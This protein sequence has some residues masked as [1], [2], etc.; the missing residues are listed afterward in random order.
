MQPE[1]P[2]DRTQIAILPRSKEPSC[3]EWIVLR[4]AFLRGPLPINGITPYTPAKTDKIVRVRIGTWNLE[5]KWSPEH[6]ALL[7]RAD[8]DVWLLTEV[9][10]DASIPGMQVHRTAEVMRPQKA[11]AAIF[12]TFDADPQ[13]DP[14]RATALAHIDGLRFMS[15]VLPW[16]SCGSS[17]PGSSLAEKQRAT[18]DALRVHI[19]ETTIWGGDWNQ[20]LEGSEYVGSLDGRDQVIELIHAARLTVPTRSLG[21]AAP[22]Q[23][24]IDHIAVPT[25]W[26]VDGAHRVPA[27]VD[28]YRLSDHDAYVISID[29]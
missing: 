27:E 8:C 10:I 28:G 20:A 18:L 9:H 23:R 12:S 1:P 29:R 16:R 19:N 21:S 22:G 11:W 6:L 5:G 24:S 26:D 4:P 3:Y 14:H 2:D 15:S 17:W 13:P 7:D 25:G